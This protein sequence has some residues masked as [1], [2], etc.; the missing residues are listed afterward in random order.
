MGSFG[1]YESAECSATPTDSNQSFEIV[2]SWM[3]HHQGMILVSICNLL[4][5]SLFQTLF[6]RE[7]RVEATAR[8]LHERP[9][10][11]YTRELVRET[12]RTAY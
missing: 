5:N 2:H 1:F 8:L 10:S 11:L 6:H 4:M 9:L 7:V 3:A 12:P